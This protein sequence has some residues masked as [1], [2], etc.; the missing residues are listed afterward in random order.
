MQRRRSKIAVRSRDAES[1]EIRPISPEDAQALA[2]RF[3]RLSD[4]SRYRRPLSPHNRLSSG[5][6][7]YFTQVD[8]HDHDALIAIDPETA[9]GVGVTRYVRSK[10]DETLAELA[11]AVVDEWQGRGVGTLLVTALAQRAREEGI[12]SFSALVLADNELMLNLLADLGRVRVLQREHGTVELTVKLP[13]ADMGYLKRLL[14]A[15]ASG[16]ITPLPRHHDAA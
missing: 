12:R 7:R 6:L 16:E 15:V 1:L 2:A 9:E 10:H 8:H 11:V 3:A 5:E 14:H 13:E 4:R